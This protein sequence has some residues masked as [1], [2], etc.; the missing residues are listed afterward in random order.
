MRLEAGAAVFALLLAVLP[1]APMSAAGQTPELGERLVAV[2]L[3]RLQEGLESGEIRPETPL[4]LTR[5]VG[6]FLDEDAPDIVL[7]GREEP[8]ASGV[9]PILVDDVVVAMQAIWLSDEVPGMTIDP[10][11]EGTD[12]SVGPFQRVVYFGKLQ[13]TRAGLYAFR[14]DYWMKRLG[15]GA[16]P[17]PIPNLQRYV[18]LLA[19]AGIRRKSGSRFWF[20]PAVP[21]LR[22]S[23]AG[24]LMVLDGAG[25]ELLTERDRS[26]FKKERTRHLYV[27]RDPVAR[28]FALSV[29]RRYDELAA[30]NPDL[31]RLRSFFSLAQLFRWVE[32]AGLVLGLARF[33]RW[34]YLL[35]E[36]VPIPTHCPTRAP[37]VTGVVVRGRMMIELTGGVSLETRLPV[38]PPVDATGRLARLASRLV[39]QRP[40]GSAP[41]WT[42][43]LSGTGSP[44]LESLRHELAVGRSLGWLRRRAG[45]LDG[46]LGIEPLE[47]GR[48]AVLH[49]SGE[50]LHLV[51]VDRDG[52]TSLASGAEAGA[53]FDELARATCRSAS[54][55]DVAFVH[56]RKVGDGFVFQ[57]GS[58]RERLTSAEISDLVNGRGSGSRLERLFLGKEATFGI[59]RDGRAVA[60]GG[61]DGRAVAR[62]GSLAGNPPPL[63]DPAL[64]VGVLQRHFAG[65]LRFHLTDDP[66]RALRHLP[67]AFGPVAASEV[68]ILIRDGGGGELPVTEQVLRSLD[69]EAIPV[70]RSLEDVTASSHLLF[71]S[72]GTR[73]EVL[74][75]L[76]ALGRRG[77]L[78]GTLVTL[79]APRGTVGLNQAQDLIERYGMVGMVHHLQEIEP[80][81][82]DEA[83]EEVGR[84]VH[85][86]QKQE[87]RIAPN[88]LLR[89]A[90][91][92]T[93]REL[94]AGSAFSNELQGSIL[95]I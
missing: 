35:H 39:R 23:P 12:R 58:R 20:Q 65:R 83:L 68:Q 2:S 90:I 27:G 38:E 24:N 3:G 37:T 77:R 26:Q 60:R 33:E 14:C 51:A 25:V 29:T 42:V 1:G 78:R 43:E 86:A 21:E 88:E 64:W 17:S 7:L 47:A 32:R 6:V 44:A 40:G 63:D 41:F 16:I 52:V 8:P 71:F 15:S 19:E 80:A 93:A 36:Y 66:T 50:E 74:D 61:R 82:L 34:E 59:Y 94:G 55:G 81:I 5:F 31:T 11:I 92:R 53:R 87:A 54:N 62:G 18:D 57:V 45:A 73:S 84:A 79:Y 46:V 89:E 49:R 10:V 76:E 4:P 48:L 91:G 75:D 13:D 69:L 85:E 56:I 28:R 72:G 95:Q 70:R 22:V 30:V 67:K 9:V